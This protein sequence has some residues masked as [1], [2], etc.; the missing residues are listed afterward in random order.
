MRELSLFTG[1]GG[2]LLAGLHLGWKAV[3]YVESDDY[4][5]CVIAARIRDGYLPDAPIFGDIR[6][7]IGDGYAA[8]YQGLV[9]VVTAGFPCQPFSLAG[10]RL[11]AEDERNLWP[12]TA[13]AIRLVRPRFVLLENSPGLA[14][15]G[16]IG[17]VLSDLATMG[18]DAQW[19]V[20]MGRLKS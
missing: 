13:A 10:R 3:G 1:G 16:Y 4:C 19:G 18:F 14:S 12:E 20:L 15:S 8:A 9:D 11:G 6:A 7:F 2:G 17:A 5:Q